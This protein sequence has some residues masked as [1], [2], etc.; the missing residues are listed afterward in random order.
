[1]YNYSLKLK[2]R[3]ESETDETFQK[4][5]LDALNIK[6]FDYEIVKKSMNELY[7]IHK[8]SFSNCIKLIQKNNKYPF[9]L[10]DIMAF[11]ILFSRHNFFETHQILGKLKENT[12]QI[13]PANNELL[14]H[15]QKC[16]E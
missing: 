4:E 8:E 10:S 6:T 15:L 14:T 2:Y 1:M 11:Q 7:T 16:F 3:N 9:T 5:F 13:N 12:A